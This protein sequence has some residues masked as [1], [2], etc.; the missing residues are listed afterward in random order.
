MSYGNRQLIETFV[1]AWGAHDVDALMACMSDDC[2]FHTVSG[3]GVLGTTH[4]GRAQVRA[5]FEASLTAFADVA[6]LDPE[7]YCDGDNCTLVS[8]FTATDDSGK[9]S[10]ARMVDL[11]TIRDGK[12]TVKNAFRKVVVA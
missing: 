7:I 11:L 5:A 9:Q 10:Q 1:S 4:T 2:V 8:T 12:I 3:T 6:W